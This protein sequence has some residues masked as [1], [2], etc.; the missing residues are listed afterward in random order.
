MPRWQLAYLAGCMAV[1]GGALAYLLC[2]FGG[3]S[4]L[5]YDAYEHRW[6]VATRPPAPTVMVYPGMLLW[7]FCGASCSAA[8]SLAIGGRVK[9]PLGK[10]TLMLVGGWSLTAVVFAA[11]YFL[12][13]LWP[14]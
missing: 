5:M 12:W 4:L 13:G 9:R 6:L 8:L 11:L 2:D 3:W 7:G 1:T 10:S 14:F